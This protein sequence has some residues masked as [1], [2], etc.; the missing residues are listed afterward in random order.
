[1]SLVHNERVKLLANSLDR[2]STACVAVGVL[3]KSL[4]LAAGTT[5]VS[6]ISVVVWLFAAL[7]LHSSGRKILGEAGFMTGD[8][9]FWY[10]LPFIIVAVGGAWLL[11]DSRHSPPKDTTHPGE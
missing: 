8:I 3:G 5:L 2:L 6:F 10:V 4:N 11:Y 7:V 1:M 9:F